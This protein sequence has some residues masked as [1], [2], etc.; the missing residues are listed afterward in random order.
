ME[1]K[2]RFI[3]F[4]PKPMKHDILLKILVTTAIILSSGL[5]SS[6][7]SVKDS[8]YYGISAKDHPV[9][10]G[11][12]ATPGDMTYT[13]DIQRDSSRQENLQKKNQNPPE[14]SFKGIHFK[15][16]PNPGNGLFH[17]EIDNQ[18]LTRFDFG[19]YDLTGKEVWQ[20]NTRCAPGCKIRIDLQPFND[21]IYLL[22]IQSGNQ[23]KVLKLL[24]Q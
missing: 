8:P 16:Y 12:N 22:K 15:V 5:A 13:P 11:D 10:S 4:N 17:L 20:K 14:L 7:V 2:S 24:K 1:P 18:K 3:V 6:A 23:Q 21:G 9:F 19:V